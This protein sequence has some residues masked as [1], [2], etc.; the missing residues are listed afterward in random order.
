MRCASP[1]DRLMDVWPRVRYPSPILVTQSSISCVALSFGTL[2]I[3]S[4]M[5][6]SSTSVMVMPQT[7]TDRT[8]SENRLPWHSGH[9]M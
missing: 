2:S 4:T 1:P 8:S 7:F 9:S 6:V 3:S 5:G